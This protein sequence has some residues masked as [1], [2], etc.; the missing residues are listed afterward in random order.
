MDYILRKLGYIKRTD[1]TEDIVAEFYGNLIG[2]P[3]DYD[4]GTKASESFFQQLANIDESD[5]Y[6][7]DM[8]AKD[9]VR[10]F[11]AA[12]DKER[13][14]VR[15]AFARTVYLENKIRSTRQPSKDIK[16]MDLRYSK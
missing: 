1:I 14:M 8:A 9:M 16:P 6:L 11:G 12:N 2:N 15:G 7:K 3:A 10:Y 4:M 5:S 13:D